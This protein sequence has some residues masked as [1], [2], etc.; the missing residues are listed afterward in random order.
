MGSVYIVHF[1]ETGEEFAYTT[2]TALCEAHDKREINIT[3]IPLTK[4]LKDNNVYR[5][6]KVIIRKFNPLNAT[7]VRKMKEERNKQIENF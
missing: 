3:R 2:I 6:R 5:N 1:I 4:N 7:Q